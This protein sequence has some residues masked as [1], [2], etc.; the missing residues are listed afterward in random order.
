[1]DI[2]EDDK[3]KWI[4][5]LPKE[6]KIPKDPYPARFNFEGKYFQVDFKIL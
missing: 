6:V 4:G 3:L 5:E 1:M 2:V